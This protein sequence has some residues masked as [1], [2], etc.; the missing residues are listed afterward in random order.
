MSYK[1]KFKKYGVG[2]GLRRD[3]KIHIEA[4]LNSKEKLINWLEIVPENF[5]D[6]GG[7][8]RIDFEDILKTQIPI[9]PHGVNLSIGT[10]PKELG[11][12]DYDPYLLDQL[13]EL[14]EEIKPPWFS[15]HLSCTRVAN[16]YLQELIPLPFT[17]EAVE[18]VANNIKFLEDR[19]QLNFLFENPSYYT[20]FTDSHLSELDFMNAIAQK[21]DCGI[22]LDVNNI[23][24]NI[25]NHADYDYKGFIDGLDLERVVQVH[26][27][28]H[29]EN[30]S[31]WLSPLKLNVLDTHGEEI[32]EEVY[33]ILEYLLAKTQI[34]AIL[35]ERDSNFPD[36]ENLKLELQKLKN[37]E[38]Q[39]GVIAA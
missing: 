7:K 10:A 29:L 30:F 27:A 13:E 24:V 19:F 28:G 8:K 20:K 6:I 36:F 22:L 39:N 38:A 9:I 37:I 25:K 18:I 33:G 15:D 12:I 2:L 16:F 4:E 11:Q 3:L 32:K 34:N 17:K 1:S 31:S 35:L 26:I 14:F 21:A 5:I 23:F